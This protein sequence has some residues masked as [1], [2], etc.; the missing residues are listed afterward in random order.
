M[1]IRKHRKVFYAFVIIFSLYFGYSLTPKSP[2]LDSFRIIELFQSWDSIFPSITDFIHEFVKFD[3]PYVKDL[4]EGLIFFLVHS[5]SE[6]YHFIFLCCAFVFSF[7]KL[8]VFD[9]F[10]R[11]YKYDSLHIIL[12]I[13]FFASIPL[14][15]INGFRFFTASWVALFAT[16]RIIVDNN[17]RYLYL[18]ALTP[19][20]HITFLFYLLTFVLS[21]AA[22]KK[23]NERII[24]FMFIVSV[25]VSMLW[26]T[27]P[28]IGNLGDSVFGHLLSSY[29]NNDYKAEIDTAVQESHFIK[30]FSPLRYLYYNIIALILYSNCKD[31]EQKKFMTFLLACLS[32]SNVV[33]FIP[34]MSRFFTVLTPLILIQF[35]KE[36]SYNKK[37]RLLVYMLPLVELFRMYQIYFDLYPTVLPKGFL[38]NILLIAY[39]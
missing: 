2:N 39:N 14:F 16:L 21:Y 23:I 20:I 8:K 24:A 33:G 22:S 15:E 32:I 10:L 7:Y 4:F 28:N 12:T 36:V 34:S 18:L 17:K 13:F 27:L 35:N 31:S 6:N 30:L 26:N 25:I 38:I 11:D 19:L 9:Y 37:I 1:D 29:I 5:F 3:N